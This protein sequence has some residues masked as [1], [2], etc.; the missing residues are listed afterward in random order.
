METCEDKKQRHKTPHRREAIYP[1]LPSQGGHHDF[2]AHACGVNERFAGTRMFR[3]YGERVQAELPSRAPVAPTHRDHR[4]NPER[5]GVFGVFAQ[6]VAGDS[7][8]LV[9]LSLRASRERQR[10]LRPP[11]GGFQAQRLMRQA[12]CFLP[13]GASASQICQVGNHRSVL[14]FQRQR[15]TQRHLRALQSPLIF[16]HNPQHIV[17]IVPVWL[18][19]HRQHR[20]VQSLSGIVASLI[21]QRHQRMG[22]AVIGFLLERQTQ[23]AQRDLPAAL[24][25]HLPA[26]LNQLIYR[27]P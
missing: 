23:V 18:I 15:S 26:Q 24:R 25:H 4:Q 16:Q 6:A 8:C 11:I 9:Q 22:I 2:G 1:E 5:V 10:Q 13:V 12:Y 7:L 17:G 27:M 21:S 14:G 19:A 3:V 20:F